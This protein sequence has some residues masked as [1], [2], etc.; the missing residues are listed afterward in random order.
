MLIAINRVYLVSTL[1]LFLIFSS[2]ILG[3][4]L[5]IN[6]F[7]LLS[8]IVYFLMLKLNITMPIKSYSNRVAVIFIYT[9]IAVFMQNFIS[10]FYNDN[11]FM[12]SDSDAMLYHTKAIKMVSM[13]SLNSAIDYYLTDMDT[14]DLGMVLVLYPLY[15]IVQSNLIL[16]FFYLFVNMITA[17]SIFKIAKN[18]MTEKYAF[19]SSVAYSLSSF[20]LLF[21]S[22]GLKESFMVML[23]LLA[24]D[25][26]YR[27]I[28]S[29]NII[30]LI[31]SIFFIASLML[32]RPA[33][34]VM[35]IG[36]I[37]LGLLFSGQV[38]GRIRAI[39][40]L[41][42]I[43][44]FVLFGDSIFAEIDDYT[45]GGIDGL[46][47]ART[48]QGSIIGGLPFTYAVNILS[49]TIGP[50]PTIISS[51]KV[52]TMFY[53]SGLI[54]RVLLSFPFWLGVIYIYKRKIYEL[55]PL[56]LFVIMEMI[57]LAFLMDGLELRIAMPHIPIVFILAFWFLDRYD[58]GVIKIEKQKRFRRFFYISMSILVLLIFYW[59]FR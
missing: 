26:Y 32:F 30:Y 25:F 54:Y 6:L 13:P 20:V 11:Y 31:S 19:L 5:Y 35:I 38:G 36:A 43:S 47:Y 7:A 18:F 46:I 8:F 15:H 24:F 51:K 28:K 58:K 23:T 9:L 21:N 55:Y 4:Y 57:A 42:F 40:L 2:K 17:L 34:S 49:Q 16:N 50:I 44:M 29:K 45:A 33:V 37:G 10:Y 3:N 39:S 1:S 14:D 12:F 56:I 27:F 48:I 41:M 59:N 52:L 53:T 22:T